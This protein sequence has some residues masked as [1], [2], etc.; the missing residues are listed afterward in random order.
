MIIKAVA[1]PGMVET[2]IGIIPLCDLTEEE[3][4]EYLE[5]LKKALTELRTRQREAWADKFNLT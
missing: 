5:L 2:D 3:F 4:Q 1:S